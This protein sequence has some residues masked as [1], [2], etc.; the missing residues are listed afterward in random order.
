MTP[1]PGCE[2]RL[3]VPNL[4]DDAGVDTGWSLGQQRMG[5]KDKQADK[6]MPCPVA[7]FFVIEVC[8][9]HHT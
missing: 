2:E 5:D 3:P 1:T 6:R 9:I 7:S 4:S 8:T